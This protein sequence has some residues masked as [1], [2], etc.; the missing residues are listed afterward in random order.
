MRKRLPE[1]LLQLCRDFRKHPTETEAMLWEC[2]RDRRFHG[3]KF[4]RQHPIGRYIA[5]SYCEALKLIIEV[6][7]GIHNLSNQ[8]EYDAVRRQGLEDQG[9]IIVRVTTE[10]VKNNLSELVQNLIPLSPWKRGQG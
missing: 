7:G 3:Y 5:D 10:D 4:R 2:L 6:D 9:F 1:Y 8:A